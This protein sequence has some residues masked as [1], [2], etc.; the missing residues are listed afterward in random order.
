MKTQP[1]ILKSL[2][3]EAITQLEAVSNYTYLT[4]KDGS[5]TM[6]SYTLQVFADIFTNNNFIRINR[7]LLVNAEFVKKHISRDGKEYLQLKNNNTIIIPRRKTEKLKI[8]FPT[9]FNN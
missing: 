8:D 2:S 9:I 7:S 5:K 3:L 4:M 1:K 6:S